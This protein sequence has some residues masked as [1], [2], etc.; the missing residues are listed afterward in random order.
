MDW[1]FETLMSL[2]FNLVAMG[3]N[4]VSGWVQDIVSF[5]K[6][7]FVNL[8]I[9]NGTYVF[10]DLYKNV[11]LPFAFAIIIY[12]LIMGLFKGFFSE[13]FFEVEEPGPLIAKSLAAFFIVGITQS[14]LG[15]F[16]KIFSKL[17]S[18]AHLDTLTIDF[19]SFGQK[20]AEIVTNS[21]Q[22]A[23]GVSQ[24]IGGVKTIL[25]LLLAII[26][27]LIL[28][29]NFL[30]ITFVLVE[31]YVLYNTLIIIAPP[32]LACFN[33]RTTVDVTKRFGKLFAQSL[34]SLLFSICFMKIYTIGVSHVGNADGNGAMFM[35]FLIVLAFAKIVYKL[36]DLLVQL[37]LLA[38]R[39]LP[40]HF[41]MP[42]LM[43]GS[44]SVSNALR[45]AR[46]GMGGFG[47]R[48]A[49]Y[50]HSGTSDV[51][52][53]TK[54]AFK[55]SDL[56]GQAGASTQ[57]PLSFNEAKDKITG[58]R[59]MKNRDAEDAVKAMMPAENFMKDG[60]PIG[61][62]DGVNP[63]MT[64]IGSKP[65]ADGRV[66]TG[67]MSFSAG[68]W[69]DMSGKYALGSEKMSD[70]AGGK[71]LNTSDITSAPLS[72][73]GDFSDTLASIAGDDGYVEG[74]S[75]DGIPMTFTDNGSGDWGVDVGGVSYPSIG[76]ALDSN[77]LSDDDMINLYNPAAAT[78]LPV[79]MSGADEMGQLFDGA[80]NITHSNGF[81]AGSDF[82]DMKDY[83]IT[84]AGNSS[85][86]GN[87]IG[88]D[89]LSHNFTGRYVSD[90]HGEDKNA[91]RLNDGNYFRFEQTSTHKSVSHI[92]P[93]GKPIS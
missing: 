10:D 77:A 50:A 83:T 63:R 47:G 71:L 53:G 19:S 43:G 64:M 61:G 26:F 76:A 48:A 59:N 30:K 44:R 36:D 93:D 28:G 2:I 87:Y 69:S 62:L 81:P 31:R 29:W 88:N 37:G 13:N 92:S 46:A 25:G 79:S 57:K 58:N 54:G 55:A 40:A 18:Y 12:N 86:S 34:I 41:P 5:D 82:A 90:L 20:I 85:F 65:G 67:G 3:L 9:N 52:K 32:A 17:L 8:F 14:V 75:S 1:I 39:P 51:E 60:K 74:Y 21:A 68:E 72:N 70:F 33:R 11:I 16:V 27:M 56:S 45:N 22:A 7:S 78:E 89:G 66:K 80:A 42:V 24:E 15:I 84:R 38:V 4:T 35:N 73:V 6:S 91:I 49:T 23:N